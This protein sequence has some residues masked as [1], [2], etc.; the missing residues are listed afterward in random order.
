MMSRSIRKHEIRKVLQNA[1]ATYQ[2]LRLRVFLG[3]ADK[4]EKRWLCIQFKALC[5]FF[6]Q[7]IFILAWGL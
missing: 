3:R 4:R 6:L 2:E 1:E 5:I 7:E